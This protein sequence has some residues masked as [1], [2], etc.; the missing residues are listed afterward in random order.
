MDFN[1]DLLLLVVI[2]FIAGIINIVAGG[3]SLL[4]LPLLIFLGL[5]SHVAN[6][7]NRIAIII[8]NIFAIKGFQSKGVTTHPFS[9]YL[10]IPAVVG[11]VIGARIALDIPDALFNKILAGV[12]IVI[13]IYMIFKPK[14]DHLKLQE[15][16]NGKY[17]WLSMF[18]FFFIGLYGGIIQAG[19]GFIV[20]MALSSINHIGLVKSNAIKV[21][22]ALIYSVAAVIVF[23]V[24]GI[25]NWKYGL[26]LAFGNAVGGWLMSRYSVKKGDGFVRIFLIVVVSILAIKLLIPNLF[27]FI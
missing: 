8:Q 22:V 21:T 5:P 2:G 25:I 16:I 27:S 4:T 9:L 1:M 14:V 24:D 26:T 18:V 12:M 15:R 10:A 23:Q 19:V 17:L 11:A 13:V 7:T 20:I 6:A 3:G